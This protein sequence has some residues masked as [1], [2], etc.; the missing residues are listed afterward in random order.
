MKAKIAA[1]LD[2]VPQ[3]DTAFAKVVKEMPEIMRASNKSATYLGSDATP[4]EVHLA[5][6]IRTTAQMYYSGNLDGTRGNDGYNDDQDLDTELAV[7]E[8]SLIDPRITGAISSPEA[9]AGRNEGYNDERDQGR[10]IAMPTMP[11]DSIIDPRI[12]EAI[13]SL[14]A[15]AGR[16]ETIN[17]RIDVD[18]SQGPDQQNEMRY[19][20]NEP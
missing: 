19:T 17:G 14:D 18:D 6:V 11:E 9:V 10:E 1:I 20:A 12:T 7:P 8:D 4:E 15:V 16:K 13:S 5:S 2:G 3:N